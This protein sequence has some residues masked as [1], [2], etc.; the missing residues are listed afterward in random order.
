MDNKIATLVPAE[1]GNW[2][3]FDVVIER[4]R[5]DGNFKLS[6]NGED[7]ADGRTFRMGLGGDKVIEH[8]AM[9]VARMENV[10]EA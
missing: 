1:N 2:Q 10:H 7:S 8:I 3:K 5:L 6:I 4:S 9:L